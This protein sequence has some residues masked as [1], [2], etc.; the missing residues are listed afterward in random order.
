[1]SGIAKTLAPILRSR[2]FAGLWEEYLPQCLLWCVDN[3]PTEDGSLEN[4]D[5]CAQLYIAPSWFCGSTKGTVSHL[6]PSSFDYLP[7]FICN[8]I[9]AK[10]RGG[11]PFGQTEHAF[12][13]LKGKIFPLGTLKSVK[14][15]LKSM[16][17]TELDPK[18]FQLD[19]PIRN[20]TPIYLFQFYTVRRGITV[21]F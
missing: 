17:A 13:D 18:W 11:D 5:A 8:R 2:Y 4:G 20:E 14:D 6:N 16:T 7:L 12:I 10:S 9:F 21:F 3:V 1:M 15:E 19:A